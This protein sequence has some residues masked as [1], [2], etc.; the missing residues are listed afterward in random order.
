MKVQHRAGGKA[1][2]DLDHAAADRLVRTIMHGIL[3]AESRNGTI[4]FRDC[5]ERRSVTI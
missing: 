4:A 1:I 5:D 3:S 2:N